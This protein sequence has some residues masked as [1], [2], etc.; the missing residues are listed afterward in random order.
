M[1]ALNPDDSCNPDSIG[2]AAMESKATAS[3]SEGARGFLFKSVFLIVWTAVLAVSVWLCWNR[4]FLLAGI[5]GAVTIMTIPLA[6][7]GTW[8]ERLTAS[9]IMPFVGLGF[10]LGVVVYFAMFR[11]TWFEAVFNNKGGGPLGLILFASSFSLAGGYLG[12]R[13]VH[14]VSRFLG[15]TSR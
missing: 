5:G 6:A 1:T 13:C 7:A 2:P 4:S 15:R 9:F 12:H 10:V 3:S 8:Q 11:F 14:L